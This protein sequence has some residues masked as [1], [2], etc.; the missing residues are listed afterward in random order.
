MTDVTATAADIVATPAIPATL[1]IPTSSATVRER[2]LDMAA[3]RG[4]HNAGLD[5]LR[6][7][8]CLMVVAFHLHLVVGIDFGP[9]NVLV[10]GGD[11]GVYIF[12]VLSGYLLYRPFVRGDVDLVSYG[13]KRAARIL[14]G[15]FVAL[16]SLMILTRNPLP[17]EH[18]LPYL[19]ISSSYSTELRAFLGNAWTLSAELIF[20]VLLPMIA[21]FARGAEINRLLLLGAA[22][23]GA[24]IAYRFA[25]GTGN[26]WLFGSFPF[27]AYAFVPGMLLAFAEVRRPA[28][29]RPLVAW[30][31]PLVGI[32]FIALETQL[33][34][35]PFAFGAAVGTPLLIIWL[36]T[37]RVPFARF[38]AFTGGASYALYLWHKDL[39]I[40]FG[41]LGF[42]LLGLLIAVAGSAAS[43]AFVERPILEA[44]HA[45]V[46]RLRPAPTRESPVPVVVP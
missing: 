39:L 13:I 30:W 5:L 2:A 19:T 32:A 33:H 15:Y 11:A 36:R 10:G 17:L 3:L 34:A 7:V 44:A 26:E 35:F 45:F 25:Y 38:L 29:L 42:G 23:A 4:G 37:V 18:P 28:L 1:A 41:L 40:T 31:T 20:Y 27:V 22:S 21:R 43:W 16:L 8:A 46:A 9:A 24:G 6:T 12:F 14:P